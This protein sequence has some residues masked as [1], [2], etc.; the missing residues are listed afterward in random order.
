[1]GSGMVFP[2]E[3]FR[4]RRQRLLDRLGDGLLLLPTAKL[5]IRNGDVFHSFRPD[6]DFYYLTGLE[7]PEA[8]LAAYRLGRGRHHAILFVR[9]RDPAREIWDGPRL[10]PKGARRKLEVDEARP[11]SDLYTRVEDLLGR[12]F[13]LFYRLGDDE[14]MDRSLST[15]FE[16]IA[17]QKHRG[18]PAAHPAIEDPRPAIA[19]Q[20]LI[21]DRYE[22]SALEKAAAIAAAGHRRAMKEALPG[23]MEYELQAELEAEFRRRGSRRNGYDS[24]VASGKNACILHY[25]ANDRRMRGGDLVLVDAGAE[26]DYYTADITRSFPVSGSFTAAQSEVYEV[27]LRAQKA[28]IRAVRAGRIWNAPH[29]AA[30]RAIVDGLIELG[31]LKGKRQ[32]HLEKETYRRWFMHGTSH[33][34]GMDVHDAGGYLDADGKPRR[35]SPG[36]V[37]TIEPGIYFGPRD[38]RVKKKYRGIG[39]R[40]ED[41]VVVTRRG[42]RV[43]TDAAP[44]EIRDIEALSNGVSTTAR[45]RPSVRGPRRA[46]G[47]PRRRAP[48]SRRAALR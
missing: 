43:L 13:R 10:G 26:A 9:P 27:V 21:K 17:I 38:R 32:A 48:S 28:A 20:R 1:M 15:V 3:V 46:S 4:E 23:M 36:M 2:A 11:T 7:E 47:S 41:D 30:T 8:F 5:Q 6:S 44:K 19:E 42:P 16:R 22:I 34:L 31:V 29:R 18:N 39:I 37:L 25:V 33:W 35:L 14:L 45:A 40:I 12:G 24:I